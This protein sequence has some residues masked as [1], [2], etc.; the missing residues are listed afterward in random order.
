MRDGD[1]FS[2]AMIGIFSKFNSGFREFFLYNFAPIFIDVFT[3]VS[4]YTLPRRLKTVK[5]ERL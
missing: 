1:V 3:L 5:V 2:V 4:T